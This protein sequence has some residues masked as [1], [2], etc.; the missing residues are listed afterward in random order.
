MKSVQVKDRTFS[1]FIPENR[2]L[3]RVDRVAAQLTQDLENEDPL[4]IC[5]LNGSFMFTADLMKRLCFPCEVTFVKMASYLGTDTTGE[6]RHLIGLNVDIKDRTV[7]VIEDII[8][9]GYTMREMVNTLKQKNP[10]EIRICTL[11]TKPGK[12][13]VEDLNI[14]Y[15]AM[16]IPNDFIVGYGLDYD[17]YGRNL[18]DIYKVVEK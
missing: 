5:V 18:R 7:V 16:E 1:I 12:R 3:E 17:G 9:T 6:V 15:C 4:F 11:L 14:D 2:I 8:D 10:K 13:K